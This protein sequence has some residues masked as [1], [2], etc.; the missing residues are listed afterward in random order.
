M[1]HSVP[2]DRYVSVKDEVR[3]RTGQPRIGRTIWTATTITR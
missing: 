2:V 1:Y 3:R